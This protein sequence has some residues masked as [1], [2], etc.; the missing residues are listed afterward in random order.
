MKDEIKIF[1]LMAH[2]RQDD[3]IDY[4]H[5]RRIRKDIQEFIGNVTDFLNFKDQEEESNG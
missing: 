3:S 1:T 5:W 2:R 4:E